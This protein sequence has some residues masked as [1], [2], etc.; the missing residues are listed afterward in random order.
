MAKNVTGELLTGRNFGERDE[1]RDMY[2]MSE[3]LGVLISV[4]FDPE[5]SNRHPRDDLP[6]QA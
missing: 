4:S 1:E 3:D 2:C 6:V 5:W